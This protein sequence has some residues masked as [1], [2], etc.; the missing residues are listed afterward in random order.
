MTSPADDAVRRALPDE[1]ADRIRAKILKG[2]LKPGDRL[3]SERELAEELQVNRG[4]VREALKKLEQLRLISIQQGS[5]IRVC[6]LEEAS[7]DLVRDIILEDGELDTSWPRDLLELSEA[8]LPGVLRLALERASA[9]ECAETAKRL[10]RAAAPERSA[11]EFG[12]ELREIQNEFARMSR[13]QV[14]LMLSHSLGRFTSD[15]MLR[16]LIATLRDRDRFLA[17]LQLLAVAVEA[18]DI[19]T[20]DRAL[21]DLL[22]H[23]TRATLE[24][25]DGGALA[26]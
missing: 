24:S 16:A 1:V 18:R 3:P 25:V 2:T 15:A 17:P 4:S 11:E 13:N 14:V 6:K 12:L 23:H 26:R 22:R 19:E 8:L 21:R 20:A 7:F 5:G 9:A 10:R